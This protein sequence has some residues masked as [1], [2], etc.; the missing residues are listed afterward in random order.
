MDVIDP[1]EVPIDVDGAPEAPPPPLPHLVDEIAWAPL[2]LPFGSSHQIELLLAFAVGGLYDDDAVR[3]ALGDIPLGTA[4]QQFLMP[5]NIIERSASLIYLMAQ[6]DVPYKLLPVSRPKATFP[7]SDDGTQV[8]TD[9][10]GFERYDALTQWLESLEL[11]PLLSSL[12]WFIPLFREAWSYYGEDPAA[13][14]MAVV[15]TLDLVIAT[16]EVDLS[17][18]RLIR[19]EAVWI[20]EDPAIEGL[21]PIQKQVLRMGPENAKILKAKAAEMRGL[22]LSQL[23][24]PT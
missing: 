4:G 21:A 11:K 6:G 20:F 15:M 19:K 8:I 1:T 18:Q 7:I 13:F 9:P 24:E 22:W 17:E 12:E 16:P 14:D 3:D 10:A 5:G 23:S 2:L